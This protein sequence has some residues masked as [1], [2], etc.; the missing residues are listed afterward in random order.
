MK[1]KQVCL[2]IGA[3]SMHLIDTGMICWVA[4]S[5]V[6]ET[7]LYRNEKPP[8]IAKICCVAGKRY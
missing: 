7:G 8:H 1:E 5:K 6:Q 3:C 4:G 2:A